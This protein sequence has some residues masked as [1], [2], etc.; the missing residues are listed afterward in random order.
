M[1]NPV[2][3][4]GFC[5]NRAWRGETRSGTIYQPKPRAKQKNGGF[6]AKNSCTG[7]QKWR[8]LP[9]AREKMPLVGNKHNY[10]PEEKPQTNSLVPLTVPPSA[11]ININTPKNLSELITVWESLNDTYKKA[12]LTM[13]GQLATHYENYKTQ[14]ARQESPPPQWNWQRKGS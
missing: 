1:I 9:H 8:N 12:L 4:V 5:P 10:N 2:R 6:A 14:N 11:T 3:F 7:L 13:A